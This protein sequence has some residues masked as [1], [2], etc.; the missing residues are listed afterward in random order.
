MNI[1]KL[2]FASLLSFTFFGLKAQTT[3]PVK[4]VYS[5][6]KLSADTYELKMTA[7]VTGNWH[8]YAQDIPDG[9]AVPT[10][11]TFDKNPLLK[12]DGKVSEV[13]KQEK[14]YDKNF[15]MN[16]KY[17]SKKVDFV[18]KVK[19]KTP[20]ITIAKGKIN[21]MVCNDEKCLPPKDVNFAISINPKG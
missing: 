1:K 9:G 18:Q 20:V 2:L 16:L 15:K 3:D 21:F 7:N 6:K 4:W 19:L 13:G 10:T 12:L 5:V 17:Y 11:F 14:V 8:I